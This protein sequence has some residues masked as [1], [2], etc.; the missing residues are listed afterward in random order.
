MQDL[1]PINESAEFEIKPELPRAPGKRFGRI[2]LGIAALLV[3]GV[4]VVAIVNR[5]AAPQGDPLARVMPSNAIVYFSIAT[6]PDQQPNFDVI[7]GA[8]RG[9]AEAEQIES[10]L[11]SGLTAS[12]F[13]WETDIL[14]WL[15]D[16]V[17]LGVVD[18][19]GV[20][21]DSDASSLPYRPPF[22]VAAVQTRDRAKSDA[23]L[24]DYRAQREN[25]LYGNSAI[26]ED[27]YRD[28]PIIY[29]TN[30]SE[31][32]PDGEA[33]ATL[34]DAIV[35]TVGPDNLKK[36]ID[37][38]LDGPNLAAGDSFNATTSALP[39]PNVGVFYMDY[40]GYFE[41][42]T[43]MMSQTS[44]VF[45]NIT[46]DMTGDADAAQR[47]EEQQRRQQEQLEQLQQIMQAFGGAGAAMTYEPGGVRFDV[48]M[49][50]DPN[51]LPEAWREVYESALTAPPN[52]IFD[53]IPALAIAAM[54]MNSPAPSWKALLNDPG[55]LA[56]MSGGFPGSEDVS[57]KI[58][59]FEQ[60]A[61]VDLEA[62]LLDL[63]DGELAFVVLSQADPPAPETGDSYSPLGRVPFEIAVMFDSSDAARASSSLDKLMNALVA[64]GGDRFSFLRPV[65]GFPAT[66]LVHEFGV[67]LAYGVVDGRLV[68]ASNPDT[69]RAIDAAD[70][71]P[72]S[73]DEAFKD[74][75][76]GLP[77]NRLATGY[78]RLAP[79][80]DWF[81]SLFSPSGQECGPCDYLRPIKW[82]ALSSDTLDEASGLMRS[83]MRIG[84]EP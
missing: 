15:G 46:A 20:D 79:V 4:A 66:E 52:R 13:D 38:A 48:A 41:A 12:G 1:Q 81:G 22:F 55:W 72:L 7:A 69:L 11:R 39:A 14:P 16:R 21:P 29:V 63:L 28:I 76:G 59:E 62:D 78:V 24:A 40:A 34:D 18:L 26:V 73:A 45:A 36:V 70:Q 50:F 71:A 27:V 44:A 77:A 5:A 83:T 35:L 9:S 30:D 65:D 17:A 68:I 54:N 37:V 74:V 67:A 57:G 61:G 47:L 49:Q 53:A 2:A 56:L 8:W 3:A 6:H 80:W 42:I 75:T 33:Y 19:G 23:F 31:Y 51:R 82:L 84:L 32:E 58:A 60:T 43:A 10:A 25:S 64:L